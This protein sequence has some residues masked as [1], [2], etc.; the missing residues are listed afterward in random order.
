[1]HLPSLTAFKNWKWRLSERS[2][3][4]DLP[5]RSVRRAL[6]A[7]CSV[8]TVVTVSA[9]EVDDYLAAQMARQHIPGL[10]LVVMKDDKPIKVKGYGLANLELGTPA[11]PETVYQIGSI[12]KQFIAAGIVLLVQE[13]KVGL[14]DSIRKYLEDAPEAWQAITIRHL[15]T[16]TSGLLRETPDLQL[17]AQSDISA[18]RAAYA[19]PLLFE[20]GEKWQYSNLGYF[21]LAEIISRTTG[22][23]WPQ[24]LHERI[25][26]RLGMNATRTTSADA[27][28]SHRAGGYHWMEDNQFRNAQIVPGVRPSGAFLSTALDLAKWDAALNSDGLF[29]PQQRELMW[30]PVKLKGGTERPYGFGWE[31]GKVGQHRQVKHGG[32]MLGFRSHLLRFPDD[33]LSI[34]V[35]TNATQAIPEKITLGVAAFY[36]S[37]LKPALP[38]RTATKIAAEV[39][40]GYT[41]SYVVSGGRVLTVA[42]REDKLTVAMPLQGLGKE[43]DQLLEGVRM[44]IALLTPEST[45]RFFD[46]EDSRSTYVFSTASDGRPQFVIEDQNG[47]ANQPARKQD[48]RK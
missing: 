5:G 27:L 28:I 9:D 35:L 14:D 30:T 31:L 7:G 26:A 13:G 21:A 22:R 43:V 2:R 17:K 25:F 29:T 16:H 34:V 4:S 46:A 48:E 36:I 20:P 1:M 18:I 12:S 40:D 11:T 41:G 32:T 47:K 10:S 38:K 23:P 3:L 39:L 19:A 8:L 33:R 45:T 42:R 24:Y 6:I 44:D 37:D 15:L